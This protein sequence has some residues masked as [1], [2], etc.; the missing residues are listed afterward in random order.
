[1]LR[2]CS[3]KNFTKHLQEGDKCTGHQAKAFAERD[4]HRLDGSVHLRTIY[5]AKADILNQSDRF[6]KD[7]WCKLQDWRREFLRLNPTI[8][9]ESN[10]HS[11]R[12][13]CQDRCI[14]HLLLG[15]HIRKGMCAYKVDLQSYCRQT[16]QKKILTQILNSSN[17]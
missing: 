4:G 9:V 15:F 8:C 11:H 6:Y 16:Q 10:V 5:R 17:I 1:M 14:R 3:D 2:A 12:F 13:D 7:D